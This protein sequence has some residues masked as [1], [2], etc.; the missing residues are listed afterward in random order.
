MQEICQKSDILNEYTHLRVLYQVKKWGKKFF[1]GDIE[2]PR[3]L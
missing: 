1:R 3:R 2:A